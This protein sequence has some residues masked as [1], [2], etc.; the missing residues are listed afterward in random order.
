MDLYRKERLTKGSVNNLF[1][2]FFFLLLISF[3]Y[4]K[5]SVSNVQAIKLIITLLHVYIHL[6]QILTSSE[7]KVIQLFTK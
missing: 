1:F 6:R 3:L 2:F 7:G 4:L 5:D